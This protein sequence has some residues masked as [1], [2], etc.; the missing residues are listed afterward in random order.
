MGQLAA[1]STFCSVGLPGQASGHPIEASPILTRPWSPQQPVLSTGSTGRGVGGEGGRRAG[2][3]GRARRR[4]E[5]FPA[6]A[7][8]SV[9]EGI[10][11]LPRGQLA[12]C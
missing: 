3:R 10:L 5:P 11:F 12:A 7:P 4:G 1:P 2:V 9:Q 6:G 8:A